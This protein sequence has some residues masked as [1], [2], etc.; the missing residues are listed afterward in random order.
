MIGTPVRIIINTAQHGTAP[1]RASEPETRSVRRSPGVDS[2]RV[3][4]RAG[5]PPDPV[6]LFSEGGEVIRLPSL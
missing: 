4:G 3:R 5:R 2:A 1:A 6:D